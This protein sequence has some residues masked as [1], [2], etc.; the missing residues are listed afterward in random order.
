MC[1]IG[2]IYKKN[3]DCEKAAVDQS[4][5]YFPRKRHKYSY[6]TVVFGRICKHYSSHRKQS[7]L[8]N[9]IRECF[10]WKIPR[11]LP[12]AYNFYVRVYKWVVH[13]AS[14]SDYNICLKCLM[15]V[16]KLYI[17]MGKI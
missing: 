12:N 6:T 3:I 14:P 9:R 15:L 11:V 5:F 16:N 7:L 10:N 13:L 17:R 8:D 1:A 2:L 4:T